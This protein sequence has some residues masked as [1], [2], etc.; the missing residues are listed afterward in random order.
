MQSRFVE[1]SQLV[2]L[3]RLVPSFAKAT[4][5]EAGGFNKRT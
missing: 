3:A 1:R 5:D 2:G 4:E